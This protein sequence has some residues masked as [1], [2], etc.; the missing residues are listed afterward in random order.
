MVHVVAEN[1]ALK[2]EP[3]FENKRHSRETKHRSA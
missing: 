2:G 3:R 1:E